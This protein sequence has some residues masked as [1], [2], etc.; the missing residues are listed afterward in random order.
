MALAMVTLR[1]QPEVAEQFWQRLAVRDRLEAKTGEW[2]LAEELNRIHQSLGGGAKKR[3][4]RG[5]ARRAATAWNAHYHNRQVNFITV[6][7]PDGP[8][9]IDGTIYKGDRIHRVTD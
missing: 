4:D 2:H 7:N 8:I 9:K 5:V 1:Y 3:V 6:R